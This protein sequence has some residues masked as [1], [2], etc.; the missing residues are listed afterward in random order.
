VQEEK[1]STFLQEILDGL[2]EFTGATAGW[3]GLAD[4]AGGISFP[5]RSGAFAE[6]W[7]T[8]QQGQAAVWGFAVGEGPVLLND[9]PALP[10]LGEPPLHNL[11][12]CSVS[13]AGE[14]GPDVLT[15]VGQT[16]APEQP[17][18]HIV[19]ANKPQ[20][21]LSHDSTALQMTAHLVS[22]HLLSSP[23]SATL[24]P[25]AALWRLGLDRTHEGVLVVDRA[26][27]LL[28]ANAAW[29]RWTG[30]PAEELIGRVAP[31]PFWVSHR[32]LATLG[33]LAPALPL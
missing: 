14:K 5:A 25:A 26:G 33:G 21:F 11:L 10:A 6:S 13:R 17:V 7:L 1:G 4:P 29:S 12:S 20:G 3:I 23:P 27:R 19:L 28:F 30:F 18:G 22:R 8:L 15:T 9:L 2:L 24:P 31:F 16:P 32:D